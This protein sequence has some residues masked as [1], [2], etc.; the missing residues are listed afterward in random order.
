MGF[1][2]E[3]SKLTSDMMK[4]IIESYGLRFAMI[5]VNFMSVPLMISLVGKSEYGNWVVILSIMNWVAISDIGLN[6]AIRNY[7]TQNKNNYNNIINCLHYSMSL[8]SLISITLIFLFLLVSPFIDVSYLLALSVGVVSALIN[9]PMTMLE[10]V[11][12]GMRKSPYVLFSQL[13]GFSLILIVLYAIGLFYKGIKIEFLSLIYSFGL[14]TI[15]AS[16]L[17]LLKVKL[18]INVR[19]PT[20]NIHSLKAPKGILKT[21]LD[22]F[23]ISLSLLIIMN[24][25]YLLVTNIFDSEDVTEYFAYERM[26]SLYNTII[27]IALIP[28]WSYI[29]TA[30]YEKNIQWAKSLVK[31]GLSLLVA[32]FLI[33]PIMIY[34]SDTF[35]QVWIGE[36]F[37]NNYINSLVF[38]LGAMVLAWNSV[39]TT[40]LNG[41]N[42]IRVQMLCYIMAAIINIPLSIFIV[43]YFNIDYIGIKIGTII[44]LLL[45]STILPIYLSSVFKKI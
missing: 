26:F 24:T 8:T 38:G 40:I 35:I 7:V 19:F 12:H 10:A 34:C 36:K 37:D 28:T 15:I 9:F 22:Y 6:S 1:I 13:I 30:L 5:I 27:T 4:Q 44:S 43:E 39:I 18:G 21:S 41:L 45:T 25:D 23:L 2:V 33:I 11:L 3:I 20:L 31:K 14:A 32:T 42:R 29:A 17:F 16:N